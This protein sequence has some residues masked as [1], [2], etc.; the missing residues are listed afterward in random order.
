M[1]H[2]RLCGKFT[3]S[4]RCLY[5]CTP[6][7]GTEETSKNEVEQ[8]PIP[9]MDNDAIQSQNQSDQKNIIA[10]IGLLLSVIGFAI[11]VTCIFG[12]I[13]CII[14]L[15]KSR[16][17]NGAGKKQAITGIVLGTIVLLLPIVATILT[18][19]FYYAK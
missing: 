10:D 9:M 19:I 14:G 2:C 13:L 18:I 8:T 15:I 5:C 12:L 6:T 11:P 3:I 7:I 1:Y 16:S 4:N 17:K